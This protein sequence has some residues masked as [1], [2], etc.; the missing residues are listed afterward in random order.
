M[1]S[2]DSS[3]MLV[4]SVE[5]ETMLWVYRP[6]LSLTYVAQPRLSK[7]LMTYTSGSVRSALSSKY[8]KDR[9]KN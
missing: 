5:M 6:F 8:W 2:T 1:S 4:P 7:Q 3:G 9:E